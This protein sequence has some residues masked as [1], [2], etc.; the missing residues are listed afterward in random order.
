M[1]LEAQILVDPTTN[2]FISTLEVSESPYG[3]S[4]TFLNNNCS[5][6]RMIFHYTGVDFQDNRLT[7]EEWQDYKQSLFLNADE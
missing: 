7:M 2:C 5:N 4:A 1:S 6:L 3:W